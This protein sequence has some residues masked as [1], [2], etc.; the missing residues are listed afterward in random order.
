MSVFASTSSSV[1]WGNNPFRSMKALQ[2]LNE[3]TWAKH[4]VRGTWVINNFH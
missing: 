3:E 4:Y 2:K 1:K